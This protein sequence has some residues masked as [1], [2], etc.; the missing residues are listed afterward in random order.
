MGE[1]TKIKRI[2][3][4]CR[5]LQKSGIGTYL[6]NILIYWLQLSNYQWILI[7]KRD[8][9]QEELDIDK[10]NCQIIEYDAPIFSIKELL[11]FPTKAV[12]DCDIFFSPNFN[13][14]LG[15]N[16]PVY[17]TIHDVVFLD[18]KDFSG[19]IGRF[20]RYISLKRAIK[21]VKKIFTVSQF[22]KERI[23]KH[24]KTNKEIIVAYNGINVDLLKFDRK[25][26][27]CKYDFKYLLYIGNIKR[28]KGLDI[29]LDALVELDK[30]LIIVGDVKG[31]KTAD[32]K[33]YKKMSSNKNII[34]SGRIKSNE[35]LYSIISN[36]EALIQ[37]SRYEGFGIP[38]LEALYLDTPVILS[39]IDV[40][41]EIYANLPVTFFKNCDCTDLKSKIQNIQKQ[42]IDKQ[43][44]IDKYNYKTTAKQIIDNF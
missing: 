10:T 40:F 23:K 19:T 20:I 18:Y 37:P 7:G 26:H 11:C 4:D 13:I 44:L 12:N 31:L 41:K 28:H 17:F 38:P 36:S 43:S 27:S 5:M 35:H 14:P 6:K 22:T 39:D 15:I 1:N 8:I 29:L 16:I 2:A 30:K 24:Y 42:S 33:N 21:K 25:K 3:V 32:K 34:L 9:I